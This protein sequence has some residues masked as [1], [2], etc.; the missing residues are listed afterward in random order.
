MSISKSGLHRDSS[1]YI[2]ARA[3]YVDGSRICYTWPCGHQ[4][5]QVLMGGPRGHKKPVHPEMVKKLAHYWSGPG[6][7]GVPMCRTCKRK[8][9]TGREVRP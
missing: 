9:L 3:E 8:G 4:R 1:T 2:R 5:T 6:G 7:V